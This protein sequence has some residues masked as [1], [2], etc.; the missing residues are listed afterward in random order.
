GGGTLG[1]KR[2]TRNG[3]RKGRMPSRF[4]FLFPVSRLL[5]AHLV[6]RE[7][8]DLLAPLADQLLHV[9]LEPLPMAA[10][11][12]HGVG[13]GEQAPHA[14]NLARLAPHAAPALGG[15]LAPLEAAPV[16]RHAPPI[17]V[18]DHDVTRGDADVGVTSAAAKPM[19]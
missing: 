5:L 16:D 17:D 9:R 12:T 10:G 1:E 2:E 18:Q 4:P 15:M 6:P 7:G 14:L 11:G 3:K 19:R 8:A 13:Q